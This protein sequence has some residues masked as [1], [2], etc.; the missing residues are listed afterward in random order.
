MKISV[1]IITYNE[2][3]N[4]ERCL[5]SVEGIAD[6]IVVVDSFSTDDTPAV[7][8]KFTKVRFL[9]REWQG[10]GNTKNWANQ[11][12]A[13]DYILSL[14]A[15][16]ALSPELFKSIQE[17]KKQKFDELR[18]FA[19]NRRT[20]YCGQ[21]IRFAGWYP[22]TKVRL[23]PKNNATWST[24]FVHETLHFSP[25]TLPV[26]HLQGDLLHYSYHSFQQ[27]RQKTYH[28]AKLHAEQMFAQRKKYSAIKKYLAATFTFVRMYFLKF[29]I[30]EGYKGIKLCQISAL[31]TYW[32]YQLLEHL[33]QKKS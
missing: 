7:C 2:A 26:Q 24:H 25:P 22:D 17:L 9:Q 14:D 21:W 12:A 10:Y 1:V 6:E 33:Y 32:K 3:Q 29:G 28:Y 15:D 23:F 20:S 19:F 31:G 5:Q 4:I 16:E 8:A 18:A 11:Q 30:F 27:H 13:Y